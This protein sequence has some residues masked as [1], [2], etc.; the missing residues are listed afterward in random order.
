M[1]SA[2]QNCDSLGSKVTDDLQTWFNYSIQFLR[3]HVSDPSYMCYEACLESVFEVALMNYNWKNQKSFIISLIFSLEEWVNEENEHSLLLFRIFAANYPSISE[4][5]REAYFEFF[6]KLKELDYLTF[7]SPL[8]GRET[9]LIIDLIHFYISKLTTLQVIQCGRLC[10]QLKQ[11]IQSSPML[12]HELKP[13][14]EWSF[15]NQSL[16]LFVLLFDCR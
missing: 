15:D 13:L 14:F 3:I 4:D 1:L 2:V 10:K 12:L 5:D 7:S 9:R 6:F 8:K 11:W 16:V